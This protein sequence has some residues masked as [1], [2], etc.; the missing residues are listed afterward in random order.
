MNWMRSLICLVRIEERRMKGIPPKKEEINSIGSFLSSTQK[1]SFPVAYTIRINS[2]DGSWFTA[3]CDELEVAGMGATKLEAM[4]SLWRCVR[5]HLLLE[6][7]IE[8]KPH[9]EKTTY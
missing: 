9:H 3:S 7:K 4:E 8:G 2:S 5:S 6:N 1:Q